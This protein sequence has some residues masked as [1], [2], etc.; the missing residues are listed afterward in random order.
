MIEKTK[1]IR[2]AI[3]GTGNIG[4]DLCFR[5]L[6]DDRFQVVAIVGRRAD[7]PGLLMF[8][9]QVDHLISNG[10]EGLIP[11]LD[12]IDGAFD[13]T[14]A[15]DHKKHWDLLSGNQKWV[16][17]LTPSKVGQPLV[18]VL[19]DK[20]SAM[21]LQDD[22]SSNYSMV[23]CGGQSSA[24]ILHAISSASS[25]I[26]EVEISSSI[27]ALSAGPATRLNID[28]YIESTEGLASLITGCNNAKAILVLNPAEPPVMMRTTV[29]ISAEVCDLELA[30][31]RAN[32][33]V[34]EVQEYVPGYE[35]VVEPYF[36]SPSTV[37]ATVKVTGAGFVL[38]EYAGNLD[39]INSAAVEAA[40]LHHMKKREVSAH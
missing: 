18:P 7:S 14:S 15:F 12:E 34:R 26:H 1:P 33:I 22:L 27:A 11:H 36:Q 30:I 6:K 21:S 3:L 9:N 10:I 31:S 5:M 16:M 38:P 24:P 20:I 13:A 40:F 4:T 8:E 37:S 29:N 17:D 19:M 32:A 35:M 25:G 23:T 2:V 39:I 28:Q